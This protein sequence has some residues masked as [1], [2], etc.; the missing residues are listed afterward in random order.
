MDRHNSPD[1]RDA[2]RVQVAAIVAQ[3]AEV[4]AQEIRLDDARAHFV[5]EQRGLIADVESL[6]LHILTQEEHLERVQ[7]DVRSRETFVARLEN[8]CSRLVRELD[9]VQHT[10]SREASEPMPRLRAA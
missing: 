6:L 5:A 10:L 2:L 4:T 7:T 8:A 1:T 3:Q 9:I